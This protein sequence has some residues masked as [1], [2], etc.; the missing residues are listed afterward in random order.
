M[1]ILSKYKIPK[2][3]HQRIKFLTIICT[4]V[5]GVVSCDKMTDNYQEYLEGG[6][7]IYPGK[8]DSIQVHPGKYR[9]E[10]QWLIMSDPSVSSATVYWNNK[11]NF[12]KVAISRTTGIDTVKVIL[13]DM[14]EQTYTFEVYTLDN[15][16]N[17]SVKTEVVG[18][19][20]GDKYRSTLLNR[21]IRSY[22][23]SEEEGLTLH[24][25]K[26]DAGTVAEE[27][28]YMDVN[29]HNRVLSFPVEQE[30]V[31]LEGYNPDLGFNLSTVF[32]P[33]SMA[34]D[35]F[36]TVSEQILIEIAKT[37]KEVN[38][39]LFSLAV[40]PGDYSTPNAAASTVDKIWTNANA[41][42]N[43][44]SYI[45][46]VDGHA[47]PQWFTI[48]LGGMYELSKLKLF[49]RGDAAGNANRLYAGG[50]LKEFEV[51]GALDPDFT[52]NPDNHGGDFGT[53]WVLLQSC[54]VNRPSGNVIPA[55]ATRP[56]NTA[57][58][59]AAAVAGHE[60][61]FT[62]TGKVRYLRIKTTA[63]WDSAKRGFANIASISLWAMQY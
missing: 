55:G 36:K 38:K 31:L 44:T 56:D 26:A 2:G 17:Q 6:E 32:M 41:I 35:T 22:N 14:E 49:Q 50:N 18:T 7:I 63:N 57:E 10:L 39:S 29:N 20:Y 46:L 24:W 11:Q 62:Y 9:V 47:L 34:I 53:G 54:V 59:I 27:I 16:G 19:V 3:I 37:E 5:C 51:W 48:D 4:L 60:Y 15:E 8:A 25:E 21:A 1:K 58:D 45:S 23:Y 13:N 33:D 12:Q 42:N 40:F 52:Y 30:N 28:A 61:S 43:G